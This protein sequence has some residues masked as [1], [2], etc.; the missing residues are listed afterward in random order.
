MS[1]FS[2][3][4][5]HVLSDLDRDNATAQVQTAIKDAV[6]HYNELK[7]YWFQEE[8]KTTQIVA[9]QEYYALPSDLDQIDTL[10]VLEDSTLSWVLTPK[11]FSWLEDRYDPGYTSR[12]VYYCQ[13]DQQFRIYPIPD[14]SLTLNLAY[15]RNLDAVTATAAYTSNWFTDGYAL[16]RFR[17]GFDVA[18]NRVKDFELAGSLKQQEIEAEAALDMR[19]RKRTRTG[20]LNPWGW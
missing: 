2:A 11:P 8:R 10:S 4:Q 17:A 15:H 20:K 19:E 1:N 12:P 13:F 3:M 6:K 7:S 14:R 16:I 18:Q 5:A 9:D